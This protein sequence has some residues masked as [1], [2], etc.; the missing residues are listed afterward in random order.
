MLCS[1]EGCE[2]R[3]F[4]L[5]YCNPH[6]QRHQK[7]GNAMIGGAIGSTQ[8]N[9]QRFLAGALASDTDDCILW[10]FNRRKGYARARIDG[11]MKTVSAYVC[12]KEHGPRPSD[13]M[14]TAH[15]CNTR[16][17]I[18]RKHVR[19]DTPKGNV[20]DQLI[21]GTRARGERHARAILSE[22]DVFAIRAM[23]GKVKSSL[24]AKQYGVA[25]HT[26]GDVIAGRNWG[27]LGA[28]VPGQG[29]ETMTNSNNILSERAMLARLS[30]TQWTA[31]KHD[32][33]V[34][35]DTNRAH[36]ASSEAGQYT[37]N[38][39]AKDALAALSRIAEAARG[40]H[41]M[42]TLPWLD[43]GQR[44]LPAAGYIVY[45]NRMREHRELFDQAAREFISSYPSFVEQAKR[46]LNG[47]FS[48]EDYPDPTVIADRFGFKTRILPVPNAQDFRVQIG[49]DSAA[50]LRADVEQ[51]GREAL[52]GAM[53]DAWE[54]I[55]DVVGRMVERLNAYKPAKE[56]GEKTEGKFHNSLTENIKDLV[57]IL[58]MLNLTNSPE[59]AAI[60][61]RMEMDL[62]EYSAQDLR[63]DET[64]R[65][66][67]AQAAQAILSEVASFLA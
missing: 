52:E 56:K 26:V 62:L 55:S 10:P 38:L 63:D 2:R 51:A 61:Q 66:S 12:E 60:I 22:R 45:V 28:I 31:K 46:D 14:E 21:H 8:R 39:V 41:S 47:L 24:L 32:K 19:W 37:K 64:A 25:V 17:C 18:N 16:A 13:D 36:G 53:R 20:A 23:A 7:H 49:D 48:I 15:N 27:W 43:D 29:E 33:R 5:G 65:K 54:R 3:A 4:R 59:M 30:I 34:S 1:I 35:D 67:T 11:S 6:W 50:I 40:A 57:A 42:L 44:I 9:A 58:P